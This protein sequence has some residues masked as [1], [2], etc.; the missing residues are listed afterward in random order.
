MCCFSFEEVFGAYVAVLGSWIRIGTLSDRKA[1]RWLHLIWRIRCID[2]KK[3]AVINASDG[4]RR[5]LHGVFWVSSNI[6]EL[7]GLWWMETTAKMDN[8]LLTKLCMLAISVLRASYSTHNSWM[9]AD[10]GLHNVRRVGN[11]CATAARSR[12]TLPLARFHS[13][14]W[15]LLRSIFERS[16]I[17]VGRLYANRWNWILRAHIVFM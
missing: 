6:N 4:S 11:Y 5:Y 14:C 13:I 15:N 3:F 10:A 1:S 7:W 17:V 9:L 2:W 16:G 8:L 12:L